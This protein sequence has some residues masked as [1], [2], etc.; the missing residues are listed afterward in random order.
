MIHPGLNFAHD[1]TAE[2]LQYVQNYHLIWSLY[3]MS[4]P[5]GLKK[6]LNQKL[7]TFCEMGYRQLNSLGPSDAIWRQRSG[8]TLAE[9]MLLVAWRHQAIT[10]TNGDLSSVS[11]SDIHL[12]ASS[13][14]KH[15]PSITE[16]IWKIKYLKFSFKFPR[17]QWVKIVLMC[18]CPYSS[19]MTPYLITKPR[20]MWWP[21]TWYKCDN[22][23][24]GVGFAI[25][26][27]CNIAWFLHFMEHFLLWLS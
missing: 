8:S 17:G 11:S 19:A 10:W 6:V 1:T 27:C 13:Q 4:E 5:H 16:I 25:D 14:E 20:T 22:K 12:R 24:G 3:S 2:L 21:V 15:Q 26:D 7:T 18:H 9:A 23:R